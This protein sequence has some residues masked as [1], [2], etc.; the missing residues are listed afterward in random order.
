M[1]VSDIV[2]N[3]G[4]MT[5]RAMLQANHRDDD[6]YPT[7]LPVKSPVSRWPGHHKRNILPFGKDDAVRCIGGSP[8]PISLSAQVTKFPSHPPEPYRLSALTIFYPF[9]PQ[10]FH[11]WAYPEF[12]KKSPSL[13]LFL[14]QQHHKDPLTG[15]GTAQ[16]S[17]Y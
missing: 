9:R 5:G 7:L 15:R 1:L 3:R 17:L 16:W 8:L 6:S 12:L 11:H 13:F 2:Y 14:L 10:I 4:R